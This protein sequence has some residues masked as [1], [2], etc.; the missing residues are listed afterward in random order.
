MFMHKAA[1]DRYK[2][3]S[4]INDLLYKSFENTSAKISKPFINT[5]HTKILVNFTR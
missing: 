3:F 5:Q 1:E 2:R 4:Y